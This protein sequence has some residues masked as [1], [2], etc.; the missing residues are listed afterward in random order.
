VP[1]RLTLAFNPSAYPIQT[2]KPAAA[3]SNTHAG[4][5][6][7]QPKSDRHDLRYADVLCSCIDQAS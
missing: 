3:G 5:D 1:R 2:N 7:L 6:Q 4:S